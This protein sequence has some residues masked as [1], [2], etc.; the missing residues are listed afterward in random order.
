MSTRVCL[1]SGGCSVSVLVQSPYFMA[2]PSG[3]SQ[4]DFDTSRARFLDVVGCRF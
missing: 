2:V 3:A 1:H 4:V